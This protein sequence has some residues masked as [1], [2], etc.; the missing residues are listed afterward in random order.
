MTV[1]GSYF[2]ACVTR[3][4]SR[5]DLPRPGRALHERVAD[6]VVMQVPEVRR[7]V[8]GLEDRQALRA[9]EVRAGPRARVQREQKAQIGARS[10]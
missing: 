8:L 4:F 2:C 7:L 9:A 5:N 6:I 1:N 10:C 3:K